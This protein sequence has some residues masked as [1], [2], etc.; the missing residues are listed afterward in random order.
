[1]L[2]RVATTGLPN[3]TDAA[4]TVGL[5]NAAGFRS[6]G[7]IVISR[8]DENQR[9]DER[10]WNLSA[11]ERWGERS[12]LRLCS[13]NGRL[14]STFCGHKNFM[15]LNEVNCMVYI[16]DHVEASYPFL[17]KGDDKHAG[18]WAR[19]RFLCRR[20]RLLYQAIPESICHAIVMLV[21]AVVLNSSTY[22]S[23]MG[24]CLLRKRL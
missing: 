23:S 14:C 8:I 12:Q 13:S 18:P 5:A 9:A 2:G 16:D 17:S 24:L 20:A 1:L 21:Y 11:A 6:L 22:S 7:S 19:V 15:K 4:R 3:S 10:E